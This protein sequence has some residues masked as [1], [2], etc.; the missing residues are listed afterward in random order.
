MKIDRAQ[1]LLNQHGKILED[2]HEHAVVNEFAD[3][4]KF[5]HES[6]R[7]FKTATWRGTTILL[8]PL[9]YE[10]HLPKQLLN[11]RFVEVGGRPEQIMCQLLDAILNFIL[12]L[13][14]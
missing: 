11:C 13:P 2:N 9:T 1:V 8:D 6:L 12:K 10:L 14:E 7:R 4:G 5:L 3:L